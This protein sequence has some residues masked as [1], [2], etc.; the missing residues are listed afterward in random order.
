MAGGAGKVAQKLAVTMKTYAQQ[1]GFTIL[2]DV[3]S[4]SSNVLWALPSTDISQA[5]VDAYNKSSGIA[6][7]AP[8]APSAAR[9]A[10]TAPRPATR[11]AP[12]PH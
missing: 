6:A 3:S 12:A 8:S 11:T 4:Q 5:V 9:P 2:L 1:S 7:P 10:A